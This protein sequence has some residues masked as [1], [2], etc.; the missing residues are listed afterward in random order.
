V[1]IGDRAVDLI[2][3]H[4]NGLKAGGVLW[5]YGSQD[6]LLAENPLYLFRS[7]SELIQLIRERKS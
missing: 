7:P 3:A 6:E 2:A 4:K 5:G 1:M